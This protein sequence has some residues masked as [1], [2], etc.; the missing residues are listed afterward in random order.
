[1]GTY[2]QPVEERLKCEIRDARAIDPL[3]SISSLTAKLS[4]TFNRSFDQRFIGKLA[5]K[6]MKEELVA[7]DRS[8]I[9]DRIAQLR[10][11][12]RLGRERLLRVLYWTPETEVL[13]G[14]R[15]PKAADNIQAAKNLV[16][17]DITVLNAEV[18]NGVYT[19]LDEAAAAHKYPALPEEKR[20]VV[21]SAFEKWGM[22]PQSAVHKIV[23][24][25]VTMVHAT[26][27]TT[28]SE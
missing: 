14:I 27:I 28:V 23:E 21:V 17:L 12:H 7:V 8:K 6:V 4:E 10:E 11:T 20:Q 26:T 16:M 24:Q 15:K 22:L 25:S 13:H 3:I 18:A 19:N 9:N 5:K 1:M 2:S